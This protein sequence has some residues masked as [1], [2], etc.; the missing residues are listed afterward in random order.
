MCEYETTCL[1]LCMYLHLHLL[2]AEH[3]AHPTVAWRRDKMRDQAYKKKKKS[4]CFPAWGLIA[5]ITT[6]WSGCTPHFQHLATSQL[7]LAFVATGPLSDTKYMNP[8]RNEAKN[9]VHSWMQLLFS[10]LQHLLSRNLQT[11]RAWVYRL[12]RKRTMDSTLGLQ[13]TISLVIQQSIDYTTN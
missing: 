12:C 6:P 10:F 1:N 9:M 13:L 11:T 2:A 7:P 3:R 5:D 4:A 8:A